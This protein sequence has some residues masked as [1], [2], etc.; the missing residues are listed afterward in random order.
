[1]AGSPLEVAPPDPNWFMS[2]PRLTAMKMRPA[3]GEH[4]AAER[5]FTEHVE[6][7]VK[8]PRNPGHFKILAEMA[9]LHSFKTDV[10]A[11]AAGALNR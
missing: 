7:C 8:N 1:M 3:R 4:A 5:D 2:P 9:A 10:A 6:A 11:A